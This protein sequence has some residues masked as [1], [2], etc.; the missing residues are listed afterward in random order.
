MGTPTN[1][2]DLHIA[3]LLLG[4]L[5][6]LLL[7]SADLPASETPQLRAIAQQ[8]AGARSIFARMVRDLD[9]LLEEEDIVGGA[10]DVDVDGAHVAH[11]S[12]GTFIRAGLLRGELCLQSF[13]GCEE[14]RGVFLTTSELVDP[15]SA[16]VV[17]PGIYLVRKRPN[18]EDHV[19]FE[20]LDQ[21][22]G[23][24]YS[25][26]FGPGRREEFSKDLTLR[27]AN[28][29]LEVCISFALWGSCWLAEV[30]VPAP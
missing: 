26:E 15:D 22:G 5:L 29:T 28:Q 3:R 4:A 19:F 17:P 13:P 14:I 10:D 11:T 18:L 24:A 25:R 16:Q 7:F 6:P 12:G 23:L 8:E 21:D 20:L 9:A 30:D 2:P 1:L 27:G